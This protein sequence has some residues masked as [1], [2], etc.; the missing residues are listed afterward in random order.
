MFFCYARATSLSRLLI[1]IQMSLNR[2]LNQIFTVLCKF[3][4]LLVQFIVL[5]VYLDSK[6]TIMH[7]ICFLLAY[8]SSISKYLNRSC[9]R[10]LINRIIYVLLTITIKSRH[11]KA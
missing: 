3:I 4:K 10:D 2:I 9:L 7:F 6:K 1:K 8:K 5:E 11:N